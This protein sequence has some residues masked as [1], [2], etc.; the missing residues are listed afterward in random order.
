MWEI[1]IL[2]IAIL[3]IIVLWFITGYNR[4]IVLKNSVDKMWSNI[5][6]LLK[7]RFDELPNLVETAKGYMKYE[8]EVFSEITKARTAF[9]GAQTI[10]EKA[11]AS[12]MLNKAMMGFY[13]VA[14]NYPKLKA[15]KS[16]KHLQ[17]RISAIETDISNKRSAYND[18]VN[19]FNIKLSQFPSMIIA[20]FMKL[21]RK[22][23]FQATESEKQNVKIQF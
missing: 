14:E 3:S 22:D 12:S 20:G 5:N 7:Q 19:I 11:K 9:S 2:A 18:G 13:A 16:F 8:K 21:K 6:V 23:L 15:D 10:D 17:E 1:I 4:F